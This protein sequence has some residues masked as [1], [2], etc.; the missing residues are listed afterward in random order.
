MSPISEGIVV[1]SRYRCRASRLQYSDRATDGETSSASVTQTCGLNVCRRRYS[2]YP[3]LTRLLLRKIV[4]ALLVECPI[5]EK[6]P[7][8]HY[9]NT[10]RVGN[11]IVAGRRTERD[12]DRLMHTYGLQ[13]LVNATHLL[14]VAYK[15]AFRKCFE[16]AFFVI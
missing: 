7:C 8:C 13:S 16:F 5:S 10:E 9:T 11:S 1:L 12:L 2:F 4:F 6:Q 3:S 14:S 15:T